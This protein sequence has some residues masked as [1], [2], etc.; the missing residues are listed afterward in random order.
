MFILFLCLILLSASTCQKEGKDCHKTITIINHSNSKV[1]YSTILYDALNSSN[2]LLSKRAELNPDESCEERLKMCWED[3][4]KQRDFE[5]FIV[6]T[7]NFNEGGFYDCDSIEYKNKI[8]KH[9]ILSKDDLEVLKQ[10]NFT[11]TYP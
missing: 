9:Y 11:I 3:E 10:N 6:D 4:L 1:I 2:C 8:L 7:L 5:F